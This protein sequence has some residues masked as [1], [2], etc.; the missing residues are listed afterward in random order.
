MPRLVNALV[1]VAIASAAST[2]PLPLMCQL[3][4]RDSAAYLLQAALHAAEPQ[5]PESGRESLRLLELALPQARAAQDLGLEG[6]TLNLIGLQ[7]TDS[8]RPEAALPYY[9]RAL[10]TLRRI[11]AEGAEATKWKRAEATTRNNI[12][13]VQ[14]DLGHPDSALAEFRA[15]LTLWSDV[16]AH[17]QTVTTLNGVGLAL[18]DLGRPDSALARF[19]EAHSVARALQDDAAEGVTLSNTGVAF[20]RLGRADSALVYLRRALPIRERTSD[21]AG[22]ST[23]LFYLAE[24][25]F[26]LARPDSALEYGK[27]SLEITHELNDRKGEA[28]TLR[29]IGSAYNAVGLPDSALA[30]HHRALG[31]QQAL[32]LRRQ[33]AVTHDAISVDYFDLELIDEGISHLRQSLGIW[34]TLDDHFELA[35]SLSDLSRAYLYLELVDSALVTARSAL[36]LQRRLH[37]RVGEASTLNRIG[38][39]YM[40]AGYADS[41]FAYYRAALDL[42]RTLLDRH[43][44]IA[45][46]RGIGG[47]YHSV[48]RYDS[49]FA[50]YQSALGLARSAGDAGNQ[51]GLL[52]DLGNILSDKNSRRRETFPDERKWSAI[53]FY[54]EALNILDETRDLRGGGVA[55]ANIGKTLV[56]LGRPD[57]A[58]PYLERALEIFQST[59]LRSAESS[60]L[61]TLGTIQVLAG[62]GELGRRHLRQAL[63]LARAT[64]SRHE[65]LPAAANLAIAYHLDPGAS[66]LDRAVAYYDTATAVLSSIQRSAGGDYRRLGAT[67]RGAELFALW[68]LAEL[69]RRHEE[70]SESTPNLAALA[71]SERGRAQALRM[72]IRERGP[73]STVA[74]RAVTQAPPPGANLLVEAGDVVAA[75]A[76][77]GAPAISYLVTP[78]T[79]LAF[80]IQPGHDV[81]V[82]RTPIHQDSLM[83]LVLELRRELEVDNP[84]SPAIQGLDLGF[85]HRLFAPPRSDSGPESWRAPARRLALILL[86]ADLRAQLP[87]ATELLIVPAGPLVLLPF[88]ALPLGERS[89]A[90]TEPDSLLGLLYALRFAP[91]L[92]LGVSLQRSTGIHPSARDALVIGNPEMPR[93]PDFDPSPPLKPLLHT[94]LEAAAVAGH[95]RAEPLLDTA[96]TEAAVR[97][98]LGSATLVHFATHVQV[99]ADDAR[100]PESFIALAPT[101]G[102]DGRLTVGEIIASVGPLRSELVVLSGC[103]TG[104]GPVTQLEGTIGLQR[105]FLARGAQ[106][107]LSSLWKVEDSATHQLM[108]RFYTNRLQPGATHAEA[109]RR[110]QVSLSLEER[111]RH[112]RFWAAFQL[113]GAP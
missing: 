27:R 36:E 85:E 105:A 24:A 79:L 10:A 88:A 56:S 60:T 41:A 37:D 63:V 54:T 20:Q 23:T 49:A 4:P 82:Y 8:G 51:G 64:R 66:D 2:A 26:T 78:D 32:G 73:G 93:R 101:P 69:S 16:P 53:I 90:A 6:A 30:Y 107:V 5:T 99:Y 61:S 62:R 48:Y 86:P 103:E 7:M 71:V 29:S 108:D 110:A 83:S 95:V 102:L 100:A 46:L 97:R 111:F 19:R 74:V 40:G 55:L 70:S 80:W 96:A 47:A 68:S 39:I 45:A 38:E 18:L 76:R 22:E 57:E 13:S 28:E 94:E 89:P 77:S 9:R 15:A 14:L 43:R 58:S 3:S 92:Q 98:H 81:Q 87:G 52:I 17:L 106:R 12:A 91:S 1:I 59:R 33:Q 25:H 31:I 34:R 112:P 21:R 50:Y 75:L 67:E 44:E 84:E 65:E 72:L 35:G 113:F 109:L 104:L 11:D 42:A